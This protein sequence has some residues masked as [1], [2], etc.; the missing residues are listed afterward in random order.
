[1]PPALYNI[2]SS[3]TDLFIVPI[4]VRA[5]VPYPKHITSEFYFPI[6]PLLALSEG[7]K[8]VGRSST[9]LP[10]SL[11]VQSGWPKQCSQLSRSLSLS[12][13][14]GSAWGSRTELIF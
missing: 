4:C 5:I 14:F 7:I 1:M 3:D 12:S 2:P 11:Q 13:Y 9:F 10:L 8:Y 6:S